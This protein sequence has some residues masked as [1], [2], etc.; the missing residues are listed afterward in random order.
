MYKQF[1]EG[2]PSTS[3]SQIRPVGKGE[4]GE[5]LTP[6]PEIGLSESTIA[7]FYS[8]IVYSWISLR[9]V[10]SV[11]NEIGIKRSSFQ[12]YSDMT[13]GKKKPFLRKKETLI[14]FFLI[15]SNSIQFNPVS[16]LHKH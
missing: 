7:S 16:N 2:N 15:V 1:L 10:E 3:S 11:G 13:E 6:H 8:W 5:A 14:I 4:G 9:P 12:I